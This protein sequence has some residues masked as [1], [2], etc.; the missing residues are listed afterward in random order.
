M[1]KWLLVGDPHAVVD[2]LDDCQR[3]IDGVF[4]TAIKNRP[5]YILFMGDQHHNHAIMHVEV[6]AFWRKALAKLTKAAP[7]I[8]LVGNHDMPG[9]GSSTSH[10]LMAYAD[11]EMVTIVDRP[12]VIDGH[13]LMPY[14]HDQV[15]FIETVNSYSCQRVFCHQ[16]FDGSKYENGFYAKDGID[17]GAF[18]GARQ[19]V[20]GHIHTPQRFQNVMYV[21]AP[22]W[23]TLSDAGI[24]RAIMTLDDTGEIELV[25]TDQWC[26][27][28]V[29]VIDHQ[30][31][32]YD[33]QVDLN[34][35][36]IV[37]IHGDDLFIKERS[38]FWAGQRIRTFRTQQAPSTIRES[39]GID[40]AIMAHLEA[41]KPRR[42]TSP[43]ILKS[44]CAERLGVM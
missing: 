38:S 25:K 16:T 31:T 13:L 29:H 26:R 3:L 35:N 37:D 8:M 9:D 10:A 12:T 27:K 17:L 36:Y 7:V 42:G 32:P 44:M 33:G 22:R 28:L 30:D 4:E 14:Y 34:W 40:K 20:S 11:M 39:M 24:D 2:E 41:F 5:D 6:M 21:G 23:R 18:K 1:G 19:F 43:A 15:K